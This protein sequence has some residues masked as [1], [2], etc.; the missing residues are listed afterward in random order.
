MNAEHRRCMN[1]RTPADAL[2]T[3][4]EPLTYNANS[5]TLLTKFLPSAANTSL[6]LA[7]PRGSADVVW[8]FRP[9]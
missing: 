9:P 8:D 7:R 3:F 4:R 5:A 1:R 6:L 2:P